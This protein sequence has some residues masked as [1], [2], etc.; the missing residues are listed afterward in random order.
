MNFEQSFKS[1]RFG[2]VNRSCWSELKQVRFLSLLRVHSFSR[3]FSST[4][5]LSP[6]YIYKYIDRSKSWVSWMLYVCAMTP[7]WAWHDCLKCVSC[8]RDSCVWE[9]DK[10]VRLVK[11]SREYHKSKESRHQTQVLADNLCVCVYVCVCL[12]VFELF[13]CICVC[14]CTC[15][16]SVNTPKH[17]K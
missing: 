17:P 3:R 9:K 12:Q 8:R 2:P 6:N 16:L 7:L 13:V 10:L 1:V 4:F 14:T 5:S 11:R 15:W